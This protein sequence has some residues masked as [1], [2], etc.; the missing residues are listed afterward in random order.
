MS[1]S[2]RPYPPTVGPYRVLRPLG[3]GG[4]A[5]VYEVEHPSTG[6]RIALK[7]LTHQLSA[8]RFEREYRTLA[9]LDHPNIVR[10]FDYGFTDDH[11][12]YL[13]MELLDGVPAQAHA[14]ASG[15]PGGVTR[16][17]EIVRIG[18][19]VA[20][21]LD[22]LHRHRI[23]HRDLKSSNVL[24]LGS[25][26]VKL[27][28][29]GTAR[30]LGSNE[31]ITRQG[32]FIGTFTYASPEQLTGQT[33]DHRSDLYS[34][35]VLLYRL[36]TGRRPFEVDDPHELARLHI[37]APP[38]PMTDFAPGLPAVLSTFIMR[39]LAKRP[40]DRP[41][42]AREVAENLRQS[43]LG[44]AP[45]AI[46][47][48]WSGEL[49]LVGRAEESA[50]LDRLLQEARPGSMLFLVGPQGSGRGRMLAEA[51]RLASA[52]NIP[53]FSATF[54]GPSGLGALTSVAWAITRELRKDGPTDP[55][56]AIL[57]DASPAPPASTRLVLFLELTSLIRKRS[58]VEGRP[59]LLAL[60]NL[61][62]AR[63]LALQAL[64]A[65]RLR[66]AEAGL[67]LVCVATVESSDGQLPPALA[68]IFPE[69][70]TLA[71]GG[72]EIAQVGQ[73]VSAMLGTETPPITLSQRLHEATAGLPGRLDGLVRAGVRA[74]ARARGRLAL[75][76]TLPQAIQVHLQSLSRVCGR[77]WESLAAAGGEAHLDLLTH[78]SGLP[79]LELRAGLLAMQREGLVEQ[80]DD[81]G[82]E[83]W[84]F[85]L[86]EFRRL[87]LDAIPAERVDELRQ[88]VASGLATAPPTAAKVRLLV[89]SGHLEPALLEAAPW[90][91]RWLDDGQPAEVLHILSPLVERLD[92]PQTTSSPL[93]ARLLLCH[94]RALSAIDAQDP[95]ADR[96]LARAM[97]LATDAA[98]Q[99]EVD[100][101]T[102]ELYRR[103]GQLDRARA[104]L[105]RANRLVD[106][107]SA[108][109][110]RALV[111]LS[112]A[113][114][115]LERGDLQ[116]AA[117]SFD[118]ARRGGE[119]AGDLRTTAR[120]RLGQAM[121]LLARGDL[122]ESE[123][124]LGR[125]SASL[126]RS[127]DDAGQWSAA[128]ALA[129]TQRLQGRLSE[130]RHTLS[131]HR[132][133]ARLTGNMGAYGELL[134]AQAELEIDLGRAEEALTLLGAL[135]RVREPLPLTVT[136]ACVRVNARAL[137]AR[138]RKAEAFE[139]LDS[140]ATLARSQG[141]VVLGALLSAWRALTLGS[142]AEADAA[143]TAALAAVEPTG[144]VLACA[145]LALCLG[146][147]RADR[148]E[149]IAIPESVQAWAASQPT[150]L[151]R[152]QLRAL[153]ADR[154]VAA[155][156]GEEALRQAELLEGSFLD[157]E[158][159]QEPPEREMLRAHPAR[160]AAARLRRGPR[161]RP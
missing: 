125:A 76:P 103:R 46:G 89:A 111:R 74:G 45:L 40:D 77:V 113:Q 99:A 52:R 19:L 134:A 64:A 86:R 37:E 21:A 49:P 104:R 29:L 44:A 63:P 78:V 139:L 10:V 17:A 7:L 121:V 56:Y 85:R 154:A 149:R 33:V 58:G 160:T 81:G 39:L 130:A 120:A 16:T 88:R 115:A 47:P 15:R 132:E 158:A 135:E 42:N 159:A 138:G 118:E 80:I 116:G 25:G 119:R 70:R 35:G 48:P 65:T 143:L 129:A 102:A 98:R 30:L 92:D 3:R 31:G 128:C 100:L 109:R 79:A 36:L 117:S 2:L 5:V 133:A 59:V 96:S 38:P 84:R 144:H 4:A 43:G 51:T 69:A 140:G 27:L 112:R 87:A 75:P 93:M 110:I 61:D 137:L 150:R 155:V 97:S 68:Q 148:G 91:E 82:V 71:L 101:Y 1:S 54:P 95:R 105:A 151:W 20:D 145:E 73:L 157:L 57:R 53:A 8:V 147:A 50:A 23:V 41:K 141:L 123:R 60:Q 127:Q 122:V 26:G 32:E 106:Q 156:E 136:L 142:E 131:R 18:A 126:V 67:P 152:L 108:P 24:V 124:E 161:S 12:P 11:F 14:K 66:A 90:A 13:T 28:D 107:A 6:E 22:Y 9:S 72:L 55:A 83:T 62:E 34:L 153:E 94:A 114:D 146:R